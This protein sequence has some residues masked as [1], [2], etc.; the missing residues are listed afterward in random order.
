[1]IVLAACA[2]VLALVVGAAAEAGPGDV[3]GAVALLV[4]FTVWPF[5]SGWVAAACAA[6]W[7]WRSRGFAFDPP[8]KHEA[9]YGKR[10]GDRLA[11]C[12]RHSR[13]WPRPSRRPAA[14]TRLR[15]CRT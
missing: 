6:V 3:G 7:F 8:S 13:C 14:F 4:I 15:S 2:Y 1:M 11:P 10:Q 12:R 5:M 9:R